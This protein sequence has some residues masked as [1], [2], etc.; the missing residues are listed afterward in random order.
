MAQNLASKFSDKVSKRLHSESVVGMVTNKNFDWT[1]VDTIKIYSVNTTPLQD[2]NR[3][4]DGDRYGE[5]TE[6]GTTTQTWQLQEDKAI[7]AT[8]D[9]LNSSQSMGVIKPGLFLAQEVD[10][11]I[12]PYVNAYVLQ[13]IV[14]AGEVANRDDIVTDAATDATNAYSNFLSIQA[15]IS[16]NL[17]KEK[18]RVAVM[19]P[20]YYN[21]LKQGGF[22][23]DSDSAYRDRKSGN[24][25][26]VDG[27]EVVIHT[28]AE[29]PANTDLVITHKDVATF[30]DTLTD[31]ITH[32]NPVGLNG[33]KIEGR[34]AFDCFVDTNKVNQIGI[35]KTA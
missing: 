31:Y 18:G 14:T 15:N 24:L 35:H 10:E 29:M 23:L 11:V 16:N 22:V 4:G 9:R 34:I 3:A 21:F 2:Y 8:I 27:C 28:S 20:A 32:K 13:T 30:A 33:W 17:G 19:T 5:R 12:V 1:G 25:G 6:V 26:T 7:N